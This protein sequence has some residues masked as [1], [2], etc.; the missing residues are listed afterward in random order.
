[1]SR[2]DLQERVRQGGTG[3]LELV[4][5]KQLQVWL[6]MW[7]LVS[8]VSRYVL[9]LLNANLSRGLFHQLTS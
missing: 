9:R 7:I 8:G 1:M 4:A 3:S 5:G 6:K 2:L